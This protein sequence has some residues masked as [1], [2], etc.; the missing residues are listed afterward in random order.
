MLLYNPNALPEKSLESE[1]FFGLALFPALDPMSRIRSKLL[2]KRAE[3]D[4]H[5]VSNEA[6]SFLLT[7]LDMLVFPSRDWKGCNR[8]QTYFKFYVQFVKEKLI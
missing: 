8:L 5:S 7:L 3:T 1:M 4:A 2:L 6:Y